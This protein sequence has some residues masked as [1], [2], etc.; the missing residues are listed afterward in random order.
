M[1]VLQAD[2]WVL[3]DLL[4]LKVACLLSQF[5][6]QRIRAIFKLKTVK[7]LSYWACL[8]VNFQEEFKVGQSFGSVNFQALLNAA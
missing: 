2:R 8:L 6:R 1:L 4:C 5:I 3:I 7:F